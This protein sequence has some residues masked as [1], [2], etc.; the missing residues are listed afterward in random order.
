MKERTCL[1]FALACCLIAGAT[2]LLGQPRQSTRS[3][4]D[5]PQTN[6]YSSDADVEAGRKIFGGR[7][8]HCHGQSGG[9][10]RGAVLNSGELHHGGSDRGLFL[11]IRNGILNTEMPGTFGLPDV[12]LWRM[13]A[14]VSRLSR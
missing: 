5:I 12:D 8:G 2:Q 4:G 9:G 10:G 14:Y 11:V 1:P 7:C 3:A 6:P 13:V